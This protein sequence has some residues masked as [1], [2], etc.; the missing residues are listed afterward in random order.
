MD[1]V[2]GVADAAEELNGRRQKQPLEGGGE[3]A[4]E[5]QG[6]GADVVAEFFWEQPVECDYLPEYAVDALLGLASVLANVGAIY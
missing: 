6:E 2:E 4:E 3:E 5:D 1:Q